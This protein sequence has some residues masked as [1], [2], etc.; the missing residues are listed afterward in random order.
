MLQPLT[1]DFKR[2]GVLLPQLSL[3]RPCAETC[4]L[5]ARIAA[6]RSNLLDIQ[7][8]AGD[9][10]VVGYIFRLGAIA[11]VFVY[12]LHMNSS[13]NGLQRCTRIIKQAVFN[14]GIG[15]LRHRIGVGIHDDG[16]LLSVPNR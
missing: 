6:E 7:T 1:P 12:I 13:M 3:Q 5:P 10:F 14:I 9:G 8:I 16:Y 2:Y 11:I 4:R 15:I